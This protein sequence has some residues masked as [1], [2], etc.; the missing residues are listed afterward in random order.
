MRKTKI[1][2]TLGPATDNEDILKSLIL[3]GMNV[4]RIN[5]SH[6]TEELRKIRVNNLKRLRQ[7]LNLPVALLL[8]TKGPEIRIGEFSTPKIYLKNKQKFTLY[9]N[10]VIGDE[11]GVSVSYKNLAKEIYPGTK[12]L[13]DDGL[14]ELKVIDCCDN[15]IVCKV[16]NG[17]S[18]S[19]NK[20]INIPD[21]KLSLPFISKT[22]KKGIKFAVDE[23]FD[24]IAASFSRSYED[25]KLLKEELEKFNGSHIKIIAKVENSEGVKNIDEILRISDGIMVARGDLGVEIPMEEIP[26]IQKKLIAKASESGK[27]VIIATQMLDSMIKQPRPTRAEAT[28]V[29]NAIYD[30]A[31][32]IML[33]AETAAGKYPV[34]SLKTMDKIAKRTEQDIDYKKRFIKRDTV[35]ESNVTAAISHATCSTAHDLGASYIITVTKSGRTAEVISKYKPN[36]PIIAGTTSKTVMRQMNLLWGVIPILMKEKKNTDELFEHIVNS[37]QNKGFVS[38]GDLV[39]LTAGVPFGVSG[40]TNLLKVHLV[41]NI[42]V[43]GVGVTKSSICTNLCVCANEKEAKKNF[44]SGDILVIP[45][46][47]NKIIGI[48]KEAGGIIT[49]LDGKNSL[50]AS[51]G[52]T[53]NKPVIIGAKN[54]TKILRSGTTVT[55]NAGK[56]IVLSDTSCFC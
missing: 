50:A 34:L 18:L 38:N 51:V 52:L 40:T 21:I 22:D 39:V 16:I 42:L 5:M 30:G 6:P 10:N 13:V 15:A 20:G 48:L 24:F 41:G 44:K 28:D 9:T 35:T 8:D 47:T 1:V 25:I 29:A 46:A 54:A 37:A 4:A 17:G 55:L 56:G 23:E 36:C 26:I 32:A 53:L 11:T 2:C 27:H 19:A 43:S 31:S 49:E 12:V 33:S 7:E 14:I 3:S 45:E